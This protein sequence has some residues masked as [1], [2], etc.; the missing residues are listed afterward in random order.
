MGFFTRF[1]TDNTG[2]ARSLLSSLEGRKLEDGFA[3][4]AEGGISSKSSSL[5][6]I[7]RLF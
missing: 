1:D 7:S 2:D 5:S 4:F 3:R 6:V